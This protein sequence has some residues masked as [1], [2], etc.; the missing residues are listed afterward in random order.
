MWVKRSQPS[1]TSLSRPNGSPGSPFPK[2]VVDSR[3]RPQSRTDWNRLGYGLMG[4]W[5]LTGAIAT[6]LN[7][8]LVQGI[9]RQAQIAFLRLRGEV[10]PPSNIVILAID[11]ESLARGADYLTDPQRYPNFRL[12]QSWPWRRAAYAQAI[13]QLMQA[14]ARSVSVDLLFTDPSLYGA[15]DDQRLAQTLRRYRGRVTLAANYAAF[16]TPE[17][18]EQVQIS[19]PHPSFQAQPS[20]YGFINF[21]QDP[22]QRVYQLAQNLI[23]QVLRP[24]RL[25][26]GIDSFAEATLRA[27]QLPHPTAA[28][29]EIFFYGPPTTFP[30]VPFWHVLDPVNWQVHLQNHTFKGKLVLIGPLASDLGNDAIPTPFSQTMPG[31]ELHANAI[32][33]LMQNRIIT[34]AVSS[35][36]LQG[37]LIGLGVIGAGAVIIACLKQPVAQLLG[38]LGVA[39]AWGTISYV[40]FT[41]GNRIV[42]TTVPIL[43]IALGGISSLVAG[44][45]STQLE[46]RR[47]RQTLDRYV[48]APIVHEILTHH[49]NDVQQLLQGRRVKAAVMFC[50]IRS[51]TTLSLTL[52]PEAFLEQLNTYFS[53]MVE[54]ILN[55]GGT[56]DKFIGD[57]IMA[58]FGS[59]C[60]QGEHADAMNA[61]QTALEMRRALAK[62]QDIWQ[63]QGK[64]IFFNGIGINFGE[65]IAGDIGSAQRREYALIGDAVNVAS[66]VEGATRTFRTDILITEFLYELVKDAVDVVCVGDQAL[67]GRGRNLVKLYSLIGLKGDDP[68]LYRQV[69]EKLAALEDTPT[70]TAAT[71]FSH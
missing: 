66:L 20:T 1:S 3:D 33:T 13:D 38:A 68:A 22:D 52:E 41:Y 64:P 16:G 40:S 12:L 17:T 59:P 60:S 35:H 25:G 54:V 67:K 58:E 44:T 10:S 30:R 4:L 21:L 51:S 5:A 62:L 43:A 8:D 71:S 27:A 14:G 56:V 34:H 2:Q 42:P 57:A 19:L 18:G 49:S 63:Q 46:Q 9:E 45:F 47:L 48:A 32:A 65:A 55:Q 61:I 28:T 39:I 24:Q 23:E 6:G 53:A 11:P 15:D 29:G 50:D 26:A 7:L 36:P 69:H 70:P 37:L 31:I